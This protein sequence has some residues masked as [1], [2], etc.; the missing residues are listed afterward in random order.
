MYRNAI[1]AG[2]FDIL[3][4]GFGSTVITYFSV[5]LFFLGERVSPYSCHYN[6]QGACKPGFPRSYP[7]ATETEPA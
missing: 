4:L 6:M 7:V 3:M 5:H 1:T 2:K